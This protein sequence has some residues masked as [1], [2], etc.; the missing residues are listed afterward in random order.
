MLSEFEIQTK[1]EQEVIDITSKVGSIVRSSKIENGICL[2]Y[3]LHS[4]AGIIINEN[5]DKRVCEDIINK[6][7]ELIPKKGNYKHDVVDSNAHAHIKA[8][9]IGPSEMII[10]KENKLVLGTWQQIGFVEFDGP[11][12]R[13]VLIKIVE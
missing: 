6:L 8:S 3:V 2:V 4:T 10:I 5:D 13:R 11:K 7:E 9:I 12:K 1:N